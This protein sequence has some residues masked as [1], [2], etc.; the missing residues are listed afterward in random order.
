M[1]L[2]P[3]PPPVDMTE[4]RKLS[5]LDRL[6]PLAVRWA[7]HGAD[8]PSYIL[9]FYVLKIAVYIFGGIALIGATT[10]GLGGI[11]NFTEWWSE[12][13]VYQK[14]MIFTMLVEVLGLAGGSGPLTF[15]FLPPFTAALYWLRPGTIRQPPWPDK[16]PFTKGDRRSGFDV[17]VFAGFLVALVVALVAPGSTENFPGSSAGV[18]EFELIW[19][20][21]VLLAILGL[22]DK[23]IYLG[24]R[25]EMYWVGS[26]I[27]L[28]PPTDMIMGFKVALCAIWFGAGVSKFTHNFP[29]AVAAMISNS[30][31]R[32]RRMRKAMYRNYPEDLH[33][34]KSAWFLAHIGTLFEIGGPIA[35]LTLEGD[36]LK[37]AVIAMVIFHFHIITTVPMGVPNEWNVFM[38]FATCF[39]F[40]AHG[41]VGFGDVEQPLL[42]AALVLVL[43]V[44]VVIGNLWPSKVSFLTS[45]RYYAANWANAVWVFRGD[46]FD[47]LQ[48]NVVRPSGTFVEQLEK[49]YDKDFAELT[50]FR[51]RAFRSLHPHGRG[52]NALLTRTFD[53]LD[54]CFVI[55]GEAI[56]ASLVGWNFG[57]GHTHH[58]QLLAAVQSRCNFAPGE[59]TLIFVESQPL[60][61]QHQEYRVVDAALGELEAGFVSMKDQI[62]AQ[63]W[64]E[65][66]H[67]TLPVT[68]TRRNVPAE[69]PYLQQ[70]LATSAR[71]GG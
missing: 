42:M 12:P 57:D 3:P 16:V 29:F 40:W 11:G 6:K 15:R 70:P 56:Q 43:L 24:A 25:A 2:K 66:G 65:G 38:I 4:W 46:S 44:P 45:M 20:Y 69:Q 1:G 39:L 27:F 68:V 13:I 47:K 55:D 7:S 36:A 58:E 52:Q 53:D 35:L 31:G 23:M 22:R 49:M 60:H 30:P 17:L 54:D 48:G 10:P 37:L 9:I 21:L 5:H 19:P 51:F 28:F 59:L 33:P 14:A 64:L 18:V 32:P 50:S 61:R 71:Q 26:F 67:S 63:P 34:S 8:L 41:E 62:E